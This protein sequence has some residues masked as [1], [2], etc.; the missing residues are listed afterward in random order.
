MD[1]ITKREPRKISAED[2]KLEGIRSTEQLLNNLPQVFADQGGSISNGKYHT[3]RS[4]TIIQR[5]AV[6]R[7]AHT[8]FGNS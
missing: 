8:S 1:D 4:G 2:I 5:S 3:L 7:V 6:I